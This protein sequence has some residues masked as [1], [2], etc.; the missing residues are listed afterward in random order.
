MHNRPADSTFDLAIW[1]I[2][3]ALSGALFYLV[4]LG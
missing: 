3:A 4:L 2:A 1:S